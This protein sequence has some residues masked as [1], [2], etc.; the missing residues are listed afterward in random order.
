MSIASARA[1]ALGLL[2]ATVL[3]FIASSSFAS[4]SEIILLRHA[5]KPDKGSNLSDRGWQRAAALP[6]IFLNRPELKRLG[7]P[8]ALYAMAPDQD[9][10]LRPMQTMK[11][12]AQTFNLPLLTPATRYQTQALVDEILGRRDLDGKQVVVCWEHHQLSDIAAELGLSPVPKY[13]SDRFDRIWMVDFDTNGNVTSFRDLPQ[14]LLDG[15]EPVSA[16]AAQ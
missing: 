16:A 14:G 6:Q 7:P 12:V 10:G 9:N 5:E 3:S 15:D 13:P 8:A 4:P 1:R 11:Y 2:M